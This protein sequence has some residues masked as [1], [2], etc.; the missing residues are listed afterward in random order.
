MKIWQVTEND[1]QIRFYWFASKKEA[2]AHK[3]SYEPPFKGADCDITSIECKG[4]RNAAG[5]ENE[6]RLAIFRSS[7]R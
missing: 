4:T 7:Q 2:M 1:N 5:G 6:L 3:R